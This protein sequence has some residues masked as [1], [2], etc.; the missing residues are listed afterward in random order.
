MN[1]QGADRIVL[2]VEDSDDDA[3]FF[4][5]A[6]EMARIPGRLIRAIDGAEAVEFLQK[7][8]EESL[9]LASTHFVFLDLK[10]PVLNGFEILKWIRARG[11]SIEVVVLSG[12]DMEADIEQARALG[13]SDY[14]VKPISTEEMKKRLLRESVSH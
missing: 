13:A 6:F 11:I 7:A 14:L 3:F 10:V 2:L 1:T 12:S 5:R 8:S 4:E 9:D